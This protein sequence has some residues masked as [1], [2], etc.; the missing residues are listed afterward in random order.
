[1][2]WV[3]AQWQSNHS[4]NRR[5][6]YMF[7]PWFWHTIGNLW[8]KGKCAVNPLLADSGILEMVAVKFWAKVR[9]IKMIAVCHH[10]VK[11]TNIKDRFQ[12]KLFYYNINMYIHKFLFERSLYYRFHV[13][14][15]IKTLTSSILNFQDITEHRK[16]ILGSVHYFLSFWLCFYRYITLCISERVYIFI[17]I[18]L[19]WSAKR[20]LHYQ[21]TATPLSRVITMWSV[22]SILLIRL[23]EIS[24]WN[25]T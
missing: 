13:L 16:V 5:H 1:M 8:E 14:T 7:I 21:T 15:S 20:P 2:N 23:D 10:S 3:Q 22:Y 12:R 24:N 18:C 4:K 25:S 11:K 17:N 9:T 19:L 6:L